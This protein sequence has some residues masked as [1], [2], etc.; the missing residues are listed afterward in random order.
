M[1]PSV[2]LIGAGPGDPGLL[3]LRGA[4]CLSRAD[5][6]LYDGLSNPRLLE[7]ARQAEWICV[8]KH[9]QSRI[10][11]Q[12]Q[13][14]EEMIRQVRAGRVV[15]RLKG[16]DPAVFARTAEEIEALT[17]EGIRFEVVPGITAALAAG[18]YAG[19]PI[20]H[21]RHASAVALVTGQEEPGKAPSSL[22]WEALARFPG[23]L[24]IYMGVTTARQWTAALLDAGKPPDTPAVI[25]RRCSLP[26]QRKIISRLDQVADELP[27]ASKLRPPVIVILG[28]VARLASEPSWFD[29][30][31]L[32]GKSVL[33][34]RSEQQA[35]EL[36]EPLEELGAEVLVQPAIAIRPLVDFS[37]LDAA[38]ATVAEQ[39]WL[40]FS[41]RNGVQHFFQRLFALGKDPRQL[42]QARIAAVGKRT[43]QA[44]ESYYLQPDLIASGMHAADLADEL[45]HSSPA[46]PPSDQAPL[47]GCRV[48][49]VRA[50]RGPETLG[51]RLSDAGAAVQAVVAYQHVDT[52]AA[53][54]EILDRMAAGEIDWVTVTSAATAHSLTRL[55]GDR[56]RQPKLASLS[57]NITRTLEQLGL[58]VAAEAIEPTMAALVA[59]IEATSRH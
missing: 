31:P 51:S 59:S 50:S 56:L 52:V 38:L 47:V 27:P 36:M 29:D 13:I 35:D 37:S 10:W 45:I 32:F 22:D 30:R 46:A 15:A 18:S 39:D 16:G 11:S 44:I 26:D 42:G 43:A 49:W 20:T 2:Y 28:E 7:H 5:V 24:V 19:V 57:P 33:V 53:E 14:H 54:P 1:R 8:G 3:T 25:L 34:T 4:E 58:S 21:R 17:A 9:G 48:L 12:P 23:T 40:V 6:V 55:F 41:S